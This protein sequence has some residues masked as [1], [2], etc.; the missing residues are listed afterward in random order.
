MVAKEFS[1]VLDILGVKVRCDLLREEHFFFG[2][3]PVSTVRRCYKKA[4]QSMVFD[5]VSESMRFSVA[6]DGGV[7][8]CREFPSGSDR[9]WLDLKSDGGIFLSLDLVDYLVVSCEEVPFS[10]FNV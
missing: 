1:V 9:V 2:V 3:I 5:D 7:Y 8:L 10:L 6:S 4:L